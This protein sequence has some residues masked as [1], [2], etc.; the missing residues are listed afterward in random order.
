M[1]SKT[2]AALFAIVLLSGC[3]RTVY[4]YSSTP[5]AP[6]PS[7]S[8][9]SQIKGEGPVQDAQRAFVGLGQGL[10]LLQSLSGK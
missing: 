6:S 4:V 8:P 1:K 10:G 3:G 2:L 5:T 9:Y 7:P